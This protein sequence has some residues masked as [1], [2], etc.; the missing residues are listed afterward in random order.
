MYLS[1]VIPAYNEEKRI[2]KTLKSIDEYLR[3]QNYLYEILV[4][5]DGSKDNTAKV[6]NDLT[7]EIKNLR[8]I[9]NKQNRGKGYVVRQGIMEAKG[10]Y[11]LFTDADNSTSIDQ[12]EKM[13]PLLEKGVDVVIGSRDLKDSVLDPPQPFLRNFILGE[14][15]KLYRK[16][17]LGLWGVEDTQ[18]GFKCFSDRMVEKVFPKCVIDRFAFD[19]EILIVANKKGYK[20]K[21]IPVYWKNDLSSTVKAS[22]M[23]KMAIDMI[24]IKFNNLKGIYN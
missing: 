19:P 17:V 12:V 10:K 18:C 21:E 14:G 6:V 22:S 2:S 7:S 5:S 3:K 23:I 8:V 15:F 1:V 4:V 11:R 9:D 16:L 20:I 13:W 24:K